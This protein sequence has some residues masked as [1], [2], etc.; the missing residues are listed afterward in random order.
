SPDFP[1]WA[2]LISSHDFD[3]TTDAV[4]NWGDPVIGVHRTYLSS[5]IRPIIWSNTQSY[6]NPRVD[7]LLEQA[8]QEPDAAKRNALYAEFQRIVTEDLPILYMTETPYHTL[9]SKKI[10]NLPQTIWGAVSPWDDV[11]LQ[12]GKEP[13]MLHYVVKRLPY[14]LV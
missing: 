8:G 13:T 9:A 1:S 5:N 11:Y 4:F 14:A 12:Y 10:G 7:E 2:K 3:M 6:S